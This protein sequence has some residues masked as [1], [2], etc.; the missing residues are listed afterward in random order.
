[1]ATTGH[2]E[3]EVRY[4]AHEAGFDAHLAKPF[5]LDTVLRFLADGRPGGYA[6]DLSEPREVCHG[7][8]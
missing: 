6:V 4:R 2:A 5:G 3:E 7:D 1:V 8:P